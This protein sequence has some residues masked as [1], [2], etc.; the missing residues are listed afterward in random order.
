M[1]FRAYKN[2]DIKYKFE[3]PKGHDTIAHNLEHPEKGQRIK[4]SHYTMYDILGSPYSNKPEHFNANY[5]QVSPT[6]VQMKHTDPA[7]FEVLTTEKHEE[8]KHKKGDYRRVGG[9]YAIDKSIFEKT[10]VPV[11]HVYD[12]QYGSMVAP[13]PIYMYGR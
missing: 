11:K 5:K 1:T 12:T 7:E 6:E 3:H 13:P 4:G 10:Y 2:P 9:E 8:P